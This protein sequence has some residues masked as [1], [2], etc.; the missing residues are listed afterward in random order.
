VQGPVRLI[1]GFDAGGAADILARPMGQWLSER[2][3]Q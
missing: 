2:L 3:G 1:V